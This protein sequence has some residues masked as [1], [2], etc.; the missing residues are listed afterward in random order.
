MMHTVIIDRYED[1]LKMKKDWNKLLNSSAHNIVFLTFE[2]LS[3]WWE[4]YGE[5]N[6]L[7]VILV[8]D[9]DEVIAIAPLMIKLNNYSNII[10]TRKIQFIS[11]NVSD[12]MDFIVSRNPKECFEAIFAEIVIRKKRW[13]YAEFAFIASN[14]PFLEYW[15]TNIARLKTFMKFINNKEASVVIDMYKNINSWQEFKKTISKKRISNLE[16]S[17]QSLS[18]MGEFS[19]NRIKEFP[20]INSQ[21]SHFITLHK[22]RCEKTGVDNLIN[23]QIK[24][25][26]YTTLARKFSDNGWFDFSS[27]K[28]D[29]K[30]I[31][32]AIGYVYNNAYYYYLPTFNQDYHKY[33]PGNLL[34]K[35]LLEDFYKEDKIKKFD[36]L[37]GKESY[38]YIWSNNE[39]CLLRIK[40]YPYRIKSILIH[41]CSVILLLKYKLL[42][43]VHDVKKL[44]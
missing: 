41:L 17:S 38:K 36:L 7:F 28:L 8:K 33:S 32:M 26:Y 19:F 2:W 25:N 34:I 11:H 30:Y 5:A 23:N 10:K 37:R 20:E 6:E 1:L 22:K 21:F 12:Y 39:I 3:S 35:Y 40:L 9:G 31:A 42:N 16:R 29:D 43:F 4:N 27:I 44:S 13:D 24:I 18:K 15:K 14:S